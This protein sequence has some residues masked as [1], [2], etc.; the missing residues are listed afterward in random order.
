MPLAGAGP[1]RT[2]RYRPRAR[3]R[4][5]AGSA[6]GFFV[7]VWLGSADP[8]RPTRLAR[9]GRSGLAIA[10]SSRRSSPAGHLVRVGCAAR[11]A[12]PAGLTVRAGLPAWPP[13]SGPSA[14]WAPAR[15]TA[16]TGTARPGRADAGTARFG[17]TPTRTTPTRTAPAWAAG[18]R[19]AGTRPQVLLPGTPGAGRWCASAPGRRASR[20][21]VRTT[22][23]TRPWISWAR[24]RA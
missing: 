17:G 2:G 19:T 20:I 23:G 6:A 15:N 11:I 21:G 10:R 1:I 13:A 18:T 8:A 5:T 3:A 7:A 16:G 12:V 14:C 4:E 22:R 24:L 9:L